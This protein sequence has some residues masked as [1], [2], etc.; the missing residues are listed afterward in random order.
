MAANIDLAIID[1]DVYVTG[2][3]FTFAVSDEQ[4]IID[5]IAA[6]PGWW[7]EYPSDGVGIFQFENSSG[8]EQLIERNIKLQ[9]QSD[10]YQCDRPD[11]VFDTNGKLII[12][13]N[14]TKV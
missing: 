6:F 12:N 13:P 11:V 2:G 5:N 8:Q 9:L 1:N 4:H 3:D 14:A 7:K 10:G